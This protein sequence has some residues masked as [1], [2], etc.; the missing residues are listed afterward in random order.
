MNVTNKDLDHYAR[1]IQRFFITY[2]QYRIDEDYHNER[3]TFYE[4]LEYKRLKSRDLRDYDNDNYYDDDRWYYDDNYNDND[5]NNYM[6]SMPN[7][8]GTDDWETY[9]DSCHI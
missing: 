2:V 3:C 7:G 1:I 6:F 5:N 4:D 9:Y 8:E